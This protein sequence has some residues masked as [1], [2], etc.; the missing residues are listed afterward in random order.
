MVGGQWGPGRSLYGD[1]WVTAPRPGRADGPGPGGRG[2]C[3]AAAARCRCGGGRGGRRGAGRPA[4]GPPAPVVGPGV[5]AASWRPWC[6][7]P[8]WRCARSTGRCWPSPS[9]CWAPG[10][11]SPGSRTAERRA[12]PPGPARRR[13]AAASVK[14]NLVDVVVLAVLLAGVL[15][16]RCAGGGGS[17]GERCGSR[18]GAG[19]VVVAL[20]LLARSRGRELAGLWDAVVRLPRGRQPG[21]RHRGLVRTG[22][23]A[24]LAGRAF[25]G[26]GAPLVLLLLAR[27]PWRVRHARDRD[28]VALTW[29]VGGA[30]GWEGCVGR[31]GWQLL[32]PLPRRD[33]CRAWWC[34]S[35][36]PWGPG[37]TPRAG[38][39]GRH[40]AAAVRVDRVVSPVGIALV[41]V[42]DVHAGRPGRPHACGRRSAAPTSRRWSTTCAPARA[43][44]AT[45]VV[46]FGERRA[47]AG[48]R[49]AAAPTPTCGACPCG[50][51]TPTGAPR[52]GA[53]RERSA[54]P[55]SCG[56]AP[57]SGP[58]AS[59]PRR[60]DRI[61]ERRYEEVFTSGDWH[62]LE[63]R[64]AT[65][66]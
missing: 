21:D 37:R 54:R 24:S 58:G 14:Q 45:G 49:P 15:L 36:S 46:A 4:A 50:C 12:G 22:E 39:A 17:C 52:G 26:T 19:V 1:Y 53:A 23:R 28:E 2:R 60:A 13:P 38:R 32:V 11:C 27:L 10:C 55:G 44:R 29:V 35:P 40:H 5:R 51:A 65:S 9:S 56:R 18:V 62:V 59:T 7:T 66:G 20:L 30:A 16:T 3:R 43:G 8:C 41:A 64:P 34:S 61:V 25:V 33:S 6:P 48:R 42:D 47:P 57:A 31:G 63:E